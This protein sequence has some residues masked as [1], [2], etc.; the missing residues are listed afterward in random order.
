LPTKDQWVPRKQLIYPLKA[1]SLCELKR[2]R[3]RDDHPTLGFFKPKVINWLVIEEDE[4]D[5]TGAQ[6]GALQQM[7]LFDTEP[8]EELQ[9]LPFKFSRLTLHGPS[10]DLYR[11][12]DERALSQ[13]EAESRR[14]V[15]KPHSVSDTKGR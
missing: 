8:P 9:K 2:V 6:R 14:W 15:G 4:S 13:G 10:D 3:D 1:A 5:W 7:N 11:L 12:G